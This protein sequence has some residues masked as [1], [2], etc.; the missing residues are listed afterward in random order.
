LQQSL[1]LEHRPKLR[2]FCKFA[3]TKEGSRFRC[4]RCGFA[5]DA[6]PITKINRIHRT[7][8]IPLVMGLGDWIAWQLGKRGLTKRRWAEWKFY[9]RITNS[10]NCDICQKR[11]EQLNRIG[12]GL[13]RWWRWPRSVIR[14]GG[15]QK[16]EH[17]EE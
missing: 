7:C 15:A 5:D 13:L 6:S 9:L 14:K 8:D 16:R 2:Q 17:R 12:D 10:K 3:W 11:Q 4:T 1:P